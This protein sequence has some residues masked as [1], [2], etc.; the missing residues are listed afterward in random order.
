[1]SDLSPNA[2]SDHHRAPILWRQRFLWAIT[3]AAAS[4][5]AFWAFTMFQASKA[6]EAET[7]DDTP[8]QDS[9]FFR[10]EETP[11]PEEKECFLGVVVARDAA[12]V[13]AENEGL[14]QRVTVRVGDQV[15]RGDLLAVLDTQ[16]LRHQLKIEQATLASAK[17]RLSQG[18][19]EANRS[20]Q[21]HARRQEMTD[22]LSK[23]ELEASRFQLETAS[24][25]LAA[26]RS[27]V[28]RAE[29]RIQQ[30]RTNLTRAEVRAPFAGTVAQRY[31]DPGSRVN[32]GTLV[33][34]LISSSGLLARFAVPP[35]RAESLD[36]GQEIRIELTELDQ[37]IVGTIQH[38]A[39][40]I[41]SASQ[42]VFLEAELGQAEQKIPSGA[43]A[44][45][46][47][48]TDGETPPSCLKT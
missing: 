6:G 27:E 2:T 8:R 29:A 22:L 9:G 47:I 3:G 1:M 34:R 10:E 17:A 32:R 46:A 18:E 11:K 30:L 38:R 39:P 12:G 4:A 40:E 24:A 16:D 20:K 7:A 26:D 33:L 31:L 19:L 41:D 23:E 35:E 48:L 14:L 28:E 25:R 15:E 36:L 42:M 43:T 21:E 5:F 44:Q 13:A 45:V 37:A